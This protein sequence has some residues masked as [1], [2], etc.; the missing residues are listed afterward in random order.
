MGCL[1]LLD[2]LLEQWY[3]FY[4][5]LLINNVKRGCHTQAKSIDN[6]RERIKEAI[7]LYLEEDFGYPI[8]K[9]KIYG[10]A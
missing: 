7:E 5:P 6:L 2:Y 4:I 1:I 9:R 3:I 8:V 10:R